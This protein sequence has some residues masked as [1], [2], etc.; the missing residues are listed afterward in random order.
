MYLRWM[1][2]QQ[3][4]ESLLRSTN[5]QGGLYRHSQAQPKRRGCKRSRTVS[6]RQAVGRNEQHTESDGAV[7]LGLR[8]H[9]GT[10]SI[11]APS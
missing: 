10:L 4:S 9:D 2:L 3:H 7:R 8:D 5:L 6:E 11:P 1:L